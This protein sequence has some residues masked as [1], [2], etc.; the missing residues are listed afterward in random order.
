MT[1]I[2]DF[3]VARFRRSQSAGVDFWSSRFL[4]NGLAEARLDRG[5]NPQRDLC[6]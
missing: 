3:I 1:L 2:H 4:P 5:F 6:W